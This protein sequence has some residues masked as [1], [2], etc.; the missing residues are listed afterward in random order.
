MIDNS[1]E[2]E[3]AADVVQRALLAVPE[4]IAGIIGYGYIDHMRHAILALLEQCSNDPTPDY[5]IA[6]MCLFVT[7]ETDTALGSI[8]R[9]TQLA[10]RN[11]RV[12]EELTMPYALA[13]VLRMTHAPP[14][15]E[16]EGVVETVISGQQP[17]IHAHW[18]TAAPTASRDEYRDV[19]ERQANDDLL[20]LAQ[21]IN[22]TRKPV[23]N[24]IPVRLGLRAI[25][26]GMPSAVP[27]LNIDCETLISQFIVPEDVT[28]KR[29]RVRRVRSPNTSR[30]SLHKVGIDVLKRQHYTNRSKRK[31]ST[32]T[33]SP[34]SRRP[35]A[36]KRGEDADLVHVDIDGATA[37]KSTVATDGSGREGAETSSTTSSGPAP[38]G[39]T[40]ADGAAAGAAA[41]AESNTA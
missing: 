24:P 33:G 3:V 5:C 16:L 35:S 4:Y 2:T 40:V 26:C 29:I 6:G 25:R 13:S 1:V 23:E 31:S 38:D 20:L 32:T 14:F 21:K 34:R 18:N 10:A 11:C 15:E 9:V 37:V 22:L 8:R 39:E 27:K 12:S 30:K 41:V 36:A 7:R 17:E 19:I 28:V